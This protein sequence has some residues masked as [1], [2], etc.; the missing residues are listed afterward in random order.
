MI[1]PSV[2]ITRLVGATV[3]ASAMLVV[4]SSQAL[5]L[6]PDP[7]GG[8]VVPGSQGPATAPSTSSHTMLWLIAAIAVIAV[9]IVAAAVLGVHQRPLVRHSQA[10]PTT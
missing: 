3:A 2:L 7:G 9:A 10:S 4:F 5:A 8:G 1:R 6:R